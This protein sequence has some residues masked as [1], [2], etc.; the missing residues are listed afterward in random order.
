MSKVLAILHSSRRFTLL[1]AMVA[2][3][4]LSFF[5]TSSQSAQAATRKPMYCTYYSDSSYS[6]EVGWAW[7]NCNGSYAQREGTTTSYRK[8]QYDYCCGDYWC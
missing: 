8:C 2:L 5:M 1:T 3:L 7:L 4:G 6:I